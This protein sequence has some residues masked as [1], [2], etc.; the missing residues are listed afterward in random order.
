MILSGT[1]GCLAH[2]S[3]QAEPARVGDDES[4]QLAQVSHH[5]FRLAVDGPRRAVCLGGCI[6]IG[7]ILSAIYKS[8]PILLHLLARV[9]FSRKRVCGWCRQLQLSAPPTFPTFLY[10]WENADHGFRL[11]EKP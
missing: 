7:Y 5:G 3:E 11:L 9:V 8:K 4:I 2:S 1:S 10:P 6:R